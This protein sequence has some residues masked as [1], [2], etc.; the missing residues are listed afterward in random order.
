VYS[1]ACGYAASC[2]DRS[3]TAGIELLD[4]RIGRVSIDEP[5]AMATGQSK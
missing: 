2:R 3:L 1:V 4:Y 5:N